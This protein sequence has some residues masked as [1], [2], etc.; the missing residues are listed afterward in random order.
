MSKLN[1]LIL[2]TFIFLGC[3]NTDETRSAVEE[4]L[5]GTVVKIVDGDTFDLLTKENTTIRIR[6]NGIDCPEKNKI[7]IKLQKMR[8]Q[9]IYLKTKFN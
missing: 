5:Y 6:I 9:H 2:F 4:E 7:F 8:W 3:T 1:L